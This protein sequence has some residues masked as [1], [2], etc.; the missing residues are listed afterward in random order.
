MV[1]LQFGQN[2]TEEVWQKVTAYNVLLQ[3]QPFPGM[4]STVP[5]YTTLS[6]T[7]DVMQVLKSPM[8]GIQC[9]DK[10]SNYLY[11]LQSPT[12]KPSKSGSIVHIPVCYGG[13][14]GPDI[15]DVASLNQLTVQ[16]VIQLHSQ[17]TYQVFMIGFIP[18][19]AYLGGLDT[20]LATPRKA[21]PRKAVPAGA[22]GI[23]G[24]Q[25]GVYPME[26]PGGWQLIGQTLLQLFDVGR[27]T[28]SLL[29]AGDLVRFDPVDYTDI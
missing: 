20:R 27:N 3:Q 16:E 10:V 15:E 9:F 22:V 1:T 7:Y 18:G 11:S 24:E 4:Q 29:K 19:F 17:P 14:F 6:V 13:D 8:P 28:P 26:T 5:A 2:I 25:T 12:I 23:A 21:L